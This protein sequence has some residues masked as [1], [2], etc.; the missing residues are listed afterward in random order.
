LICI[1]WLC[2]KCTSYISFLVET[3]VS[4]KYRMYH[5]QTGISWLL[6]FLFVSLSFLCHTLLLWLRIPAPHWLRQWTPCLI[7]HFRENA[8]SLS[9]VSI[10]LTLVLWHIA[11]IM[12]S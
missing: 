3:S 9:T 10:M 12:L 8:F 5:V 6:P 11:F 4:F 1:L 7:P 2:H